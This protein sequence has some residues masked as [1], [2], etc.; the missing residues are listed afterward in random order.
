M[1]EEAD[2]EEMT[3][4]INMKKPHARVFMVAWRELKAIPEGVPPDDF[5][6][7]PEPE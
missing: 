2:I 1:A 3:V 6:P 4:D 7:E 5:E